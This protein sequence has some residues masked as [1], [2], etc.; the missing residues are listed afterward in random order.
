MKLPES[1]SFDGVDGSNDRTDFYLAALN[2]HD[3]YLPLATV[4]RHM[5][6]TARLWT[7]HAAIHPLSDT[8]VTFSR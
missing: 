1:M 4:A 6:T 2:S 3:G 7:H 5:W 8:S